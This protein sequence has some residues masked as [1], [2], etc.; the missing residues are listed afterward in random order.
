MPSTKSLPVPFC[1]LPAHCPYLLGSTHACL[2]WPA[3]SHYS[4]LSFR[5]LSLGDPPDAPQARL[6]PPSSQKTQGL[7][8]D[9]FAEFEIKYFLVQLCVTSA[10][11]K[12]S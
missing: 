2:F 1:F 7:S 12:V 10:R 9:E 3:I 6:G 4:G 8:F 5:V 11:P